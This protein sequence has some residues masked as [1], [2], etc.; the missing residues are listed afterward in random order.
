MIVDFHTHCFPDRLAPRALE[1]LSREGGGWQPGTDGTAAGLLRSMD[2]AGVA[3]S[4]VAN[5]AT[6][7][8]QMHAVND[9]AASI[10]GERLAAFGSVHPDAPDALEELERIRD[11]GLKGVKFHPEYQGFW[12]DEERMLPLWRKISSLG[13][14]VLFHAGGDIAFPAPWRGMPEHI[15][16]ALPHLDCPVVAAHWGG[17]YCTEEVQKHLCG[18]PVYL[19]TSLGYG[20]T[21]RPQAMAILAAHGTNRVLFGTDT[22][23]HTPEDELRYLSTLELSPE[24]YAAVTGG[25]ACRL[26]G[27]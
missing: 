14:I 1:T 10:N 6:N 11:L 18:L 23:W 20:V 25:N 17:A 21:P 4:V 19:D 15:A 2:R 8:R 5:I 7:P 3:V 13:L 24:E 22:P 26:L 9:F 16:R 12:P 27:I